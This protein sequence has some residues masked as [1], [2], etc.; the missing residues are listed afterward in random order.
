[1]ADNRRRLREGR[2]LLNVVDRSR[3]Y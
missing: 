2:P 1:V 3:G